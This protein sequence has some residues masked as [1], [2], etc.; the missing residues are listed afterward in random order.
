MVASRCL[1]AYSKF[2]PPD[3]FDRII[4]YSPALPQ[5]SMMCCVCLM[6]G[7]AHRT[8]LSVEAGD[9]RAQWK[10]RH[11]YTLTLM[12]ILSFAFERVNS[13]EALLDVAYNHISAMLKDDKPPVKKAAVSCAECYLLRLNADHPGPHSSSGL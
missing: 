3:E 7:C 8:E 13:N 6:H 1:A 10:L 4:K 12:F 2:C 5:R 9:V 11:A